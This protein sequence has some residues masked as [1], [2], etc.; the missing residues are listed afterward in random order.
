M[1]GCFD[2]EQRNM[3]PIADAVAKLQER[4]K[5][6][7][8]KSDLV[9]KHISLRKEMCENN[10]EVFFKKYNSLFEHIKRL[11]DG[12]ED[13]KK[14][15]SQSH[16]C[17]EKYIE[18][19][20]KIRQMQVDYETHCEAILALEEKMKKLQEE[21]GNVSYLVGVQQGKAI[22]SFYPKQP[23]KCPACN[24]FGKRYDSNAIEHGKDKMGYYG[25]HETCIACEGKGIIIC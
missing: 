12:I 20:E 10:H 24:G 19:T 18:T 15:K 11:E 3:S 7:E 4:V 25:K 1:S 22:G 8:E 9:E 16:I 23:H 17:A 6:L 13:L 2:S 21:V 14:T 5:A